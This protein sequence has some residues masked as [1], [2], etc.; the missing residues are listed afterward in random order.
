MSSEGHHLYAKRR[1][2]PIMILLAISNGGANEQRSQEFYYVTQLENQGKDS[3][4]SA[5]TNYFSFR[6]SS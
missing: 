3:F 6:I 2:Q 1:V 5:L 4:E